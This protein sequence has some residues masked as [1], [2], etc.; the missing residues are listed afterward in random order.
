M[1]DQVDPWR[2][3]GLAAARG[4][5]DADPGGATGCQG[6]GQG[7]DQGKCPAQDLGRR[8]ACKPLSTSSQGRSDLTL[9][10]LRIPNAAYL[11]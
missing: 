10:V 5:G 1:Q 3:P 6:Q 11:P 8:Q 7:Q 9:G 4:A 2:K